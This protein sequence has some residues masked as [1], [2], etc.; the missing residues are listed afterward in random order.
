MINLY[1][2]PGSCALASHIA[3]EE[4]EAEYT[5]HRVDFSQNQQQSQEF[6]KVNPK[7]RVPALITDKGILTETPAALVYIAQTHPAANLAPMDDPF[8]FAQLQA[9]NS[10]L[11]STVHVAHAHKGRGSRWSD[12][13]SAW[14]S[15]KRKVPDSMAQCF[16]Y[17]E[18]HAFVGP[19]ALG[20]NYTVTDGYLYTVARWLAG[21]GVDT[22]QFPKVHTHMQMMANRPAVQRALMAEGVES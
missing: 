6:L 20:D 1:Y 12:D 16:R 7:G 10:Y 17:I 2:S 14:D 11:A 21:D 15:M 8:A 13:E 3:L 5:G 9:F 18:D 4:A 22:A 19:C